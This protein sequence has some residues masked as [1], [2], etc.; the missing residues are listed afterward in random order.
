LHDVEDER[1]DFANFS[2]LHNFGDGALLTISPFTTSIAHII[3]A[4]LTI[5][6]APILIADQISWVA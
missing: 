6:S 3:S 2:W 1:D 5:P 4:A